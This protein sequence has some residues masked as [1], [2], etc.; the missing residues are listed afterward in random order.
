MLP[1]RYTIRPIWVIALLLWLFNAPA[2]AVKVGDLAPDFT[3]E[4][5]EGDTIALSS[6]Q[7][8]VV[9]LYFFGWD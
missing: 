1:V 4:E 9:L 6:L 3:L 2:Q 5:V 8:R 7:G